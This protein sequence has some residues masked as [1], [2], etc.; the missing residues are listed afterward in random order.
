MPG[1]F[2]PLAG[3]LAA[4]GTILLAPQVWPFVERPVA[5]A[6]FELYGQ[7][8]ATWVFWV[9]KLGF[10]PLTFF[11]LRLGILGA[12]MWLSLVAARRLM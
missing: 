2:G 3:L 9:A 1:A 6:I 10:W 7:E 12:F 8:Y 11:S 5:E 4:G